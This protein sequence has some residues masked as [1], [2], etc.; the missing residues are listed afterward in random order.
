MSLVALWTIARATLHEALRR[1]ILAAAVGFGLLFVALFA[2]GLTVARDQLAKDSGTPAA[3]Q[4]IMLNFFVL[5]G[6]YAVN[7]LTILTA[8]CLPVDTLSGEIQSGVMQT[9]AA[10]PIS[11]ATIVLGKWLGHWLV[12]VGYIA[13]V[14][15]GLL[16]VARVIAGVT[17]P[18]LAA[19]LALL[20]LE[21][22]IM[23]STSIALGTRLSTIANAMTCIGLYG[24]AFLGGWFEQVATHIGTP[25][26]RQVGVVASLVF[27]S[28]AMWQFAAHLM[29]PPLTRDLH[30]TPLSPASVPSPFM[31]AWAIGYCVI[32]LVLALRWMSR[33]PL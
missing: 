10:K 15:G 16:V 26:A 22:T 23:L 8:A 32:A 31:V 33:R 7:F 25:A 4:P 12:L 24:L 5:A 14:A 20:V 1:R 9:V 18:N 29:Q 13:L 6:L 19:G 2:I 30:I 27:P 17:P 21:G 3:F 11:R 28:E